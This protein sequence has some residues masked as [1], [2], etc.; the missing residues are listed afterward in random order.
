M[1]VKSGDDL[2]QELLAMQLIKQFQ[3]RYRVL[4][5][6]PDPL[7]LAVCMLFKGTLSV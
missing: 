1:I 5:S 4:V 6:Y 7:Q 2:R 3:V